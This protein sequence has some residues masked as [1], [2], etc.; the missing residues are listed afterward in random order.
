MVKFRNLRAD[1]IEVRPTDTK[2]GGATLLLYKDARTDRRI[3]DETFGSENW[4]CEFYEVNG[5]TFCRVGIWFEDKQRWIWKSDCGSESNIEK[6]KG[7]AS[8]AF[9]RACFKWGLG[10]ELYSIPRIKI[11]CPDKWYYNDKMTMTFKV[12]RFKAEGE[13]IKQL[14]IVDKFGNVIYRFPPKKEDDREYREEEGPA[15]ETTTDDTLERLKEYCGKVKK[16][17]ASD[18]KENRFHLRKFYEYWSGK[19]IDE[20]FDLRSPKVMWE[21]WNSQTDKRKKEWEREL[22]AQDRAKTRSDL[23]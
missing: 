6:D 18:D 11:T 13:E 15:E 20:G 14:E 2:Y 7:L 4:Q 22:Y 12:S 16:T 17:L 10:V 5:A 21:K 8:D 3:L 1:E 19:I 9:K 23:E